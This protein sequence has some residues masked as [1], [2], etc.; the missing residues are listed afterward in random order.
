VTFNEVDEQLAILESAFVISQAV[1]SEV[2]PGG[3]YS[4]PAQPVEPFLA[5]RIPLDDN[6][7]NG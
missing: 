2:Q 4:P 5:C 6:A 7:G 1:F 3:C